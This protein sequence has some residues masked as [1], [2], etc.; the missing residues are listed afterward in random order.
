M[1]PCLAAQ[2]FPYLSLLLLFLFVPCCST[3]DRNELGEIFKREE[4]SSKFDAALKAR[5]WL[6]EMDKNHDKAVS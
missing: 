5:K 4:G 6:Q 1:S 2:F 3:L